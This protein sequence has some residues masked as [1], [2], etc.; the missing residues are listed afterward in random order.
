MTDFIFK[1]VRQSSFANKKL[2]LQMQTAPQL[3]YLIPNNTGLASSGLEKAVVE[4]NLPARTSEHVKTLAI[5]DGYYISAETN[6]IVNELPSQILQILRQAVKDSAKKTATSNL[7]ANHDVDH[8]RDYDRSHDRVHQ[9]DNNQNPLT[10]VNFAFAY[11]QWGTNNFPKVSVP[12]DAGLK[13]NLKAAFNFWCLRK[14]CYWTFYQV[15]TGQELIKDAIST[16]DIQSYDLNSQQ[17]LNAIKAKLEGNGYDFR[18]LDSA[19]QAIIAELIAHYCQRSYLQVLQLRNSWEKQTDRKQMMTDVLADQMVQEAITSTTKKSPKELAKDGSALEQQTKQAQADIDEIASDIRLSM[20]KKFDWTLTRFWNR[21]YSGF[22]VRGLDRLRNLNFTEPDL[23]LIYVSTHRSHI[24]YLLLSYVLNNYAGIKIPNIAA[25]INLNFFPVG[26]I[27]R[28]GGAFF[29]R[30]SFNNYLY[31]QVFKTYI[32]KLVANHDDLEFFIEGGRSRTGRLLTPKTGML[33]MTIEAYMNNPTHNTYYVPVFIAYDKVFESRTYTEELQ[34]KPKNKESA[35]LVLRNFSKLK[36]Q[37]QVHVNFARPIKISDIF[38]QIYPNFLEDKANNS[39]DKAKLDLVSETLARANM[40]GI[41]GDITVSEKALF[42]ANLFNSNGEFPR[43]ELYAN[44]EFLREVVQQ[45]KQF[46]PLYT[47][48]QTPVADLVNNILKVLKKHTIRN[49]EQVVAIKPSK[50][51]E[52][53]YYRNNIEHVFI[54]PALAAISLQKDLNQAQ[55]KEFTN[56]FSDIFNHNSFTDFKAGELETQVLFFKSW[57][58]QHLVVEDKARL[59]ELLAAQLQTYLRLIEA[60]LRATQLEIA[61]LQA[62]GKDADS[63]VQSAI[64]NQMLTLLKEYQSIYPD[65]TD[66]TTINQ[67]RTAFMST[68]S[69]DFRSSEVLKQAEAAIQPWM[70]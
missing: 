12:R 26:T 11:Q 60:Y 27:F 66:K 53:N 25:G 31:S 21:F 13:R 37:G 5:Q 59:L 1:L 54:A 2:Q 30:R 8:D 67:L 55:I 9:Q 61:K 23:N 32:S 18:E 51:A 34:G 64:S 10:D 45:T 7:E 65:L 44:L 33:N 48:V 28:R 50:L 70:S 46:N 40:V 17:E 57:L 41:N 15:V 68:K 49:D 6:E 63:L 39:L 3:V 24:D 38:A 47:V 69:H 20:V 19:Q 36:Y 29:L 62:E 58:E 43:A 56:F 52:F 35:L 22:N 42:S 14:Y 16:L 4:L